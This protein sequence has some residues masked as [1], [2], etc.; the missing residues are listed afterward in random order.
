[1]PNQVRIAV[2]KGKFP[3]TIDCKVF[4]DE[5]NTDIIKSQPNNFHLYFYSL[6]ELVKHEDNGLIFHDSK[7]LAQQLKVS[8]K[9]AVVS[10]SQDVD[11]Y[12]R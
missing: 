1:M 2:R 12:P 4:T 9:I 11:S 8:F 5:S 10:F 3:V 6:H 7:E